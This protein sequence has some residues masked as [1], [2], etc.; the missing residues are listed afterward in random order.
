MDSNDFVSLGLPAPI[1]DALRMAEY[2]TPSPI[3]ARTIPLLLAGKDVIAQAQTGTGKTAAFAIPFLSGLDLSLRPPQVKV[4]V[5]TPTRELA[6]QVAESFSKYG[7]QLR[8]LRVLPI[9]GGQ[10]Y[11]VQIQALKRGVHV[12]VGTPGRVMDHMRR[13]TLSLAHLS[14]VVLDEADEML[15]MGFIDDVE[16]VLSQSPAQ[17][18]IALFSATMPAEI[19]RIAS[20]YLRAPEQ[21]IIENRATAA[22][23]I[24]QKAWVVAGMSKAEALSRMLETADSDGVIVFVKTRSGAIEL[25]D[26]LLER[27]HSVA[28]LNGDM[29]Q[30]QRE[31]TIERL[32]RGQIKVLVATDVAARGL[33]VDRLSHVINF[34]APFDAETYVHRIG[35]TGRAGREGESI[36]FV[37]HRERRLLQTIARTT[38]QP[39]ALI[40]PPTVAEINRLRIARFQ[41]QIGAAMASPEFSFFKE[42]VASYRVENN[43]DED[44]VAAAIAVMLQGERPLRMKKDRP[45]NTE[46]LFASSPGVAPDLRAA[47]PSVRYVIEVGR[48]HGVSAGN[49]VGAIANETGLSGAAIG[50]IEIY[51]AH[52]TVDLPEGMPD[53]VLQHL[54]KVW[55]CERQL[56]IRRWEKQDAVHLQGAAGP[57]QAFSKKAAHFSPKRAK[58]THK[59][60]K[61]PHKAPHKASQKASHKASK[62]TAAPQPRNVA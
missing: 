29:N 23:T 4:L 47:A 30:K 43:C 58:A 60:N 49:I 2:A 14:G 20:Q 61:A 25:A 34:D 44:D 52:S 51:P 3:Q 11:G 22:A 55:V 18:Q 35:R 48:E 7:C 32:K 40:H 13:G 8:G 57:P 24:A 33:D 54:Q 41:A 1:L 42:L 16:W 6:M 56:C 10:D 19:R 38:R 46:A 59:R 17:R 36:L 39:I 9:Y 62:R 37:T 21:V 45:E 27:G 15:R 26:A 28:A 12:V 5:L 31:H 53:N 50:R